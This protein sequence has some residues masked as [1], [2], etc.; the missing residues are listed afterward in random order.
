VLTATLRSGHATL[1]EFSSRQHIFNWTRSEQLPS[2]PGLLE[3]MGCR[4]AAYL[5]VMV[6]KIEVKQYLLNIWH[7]SP[8]ND[9]AVYEGVGILE[10]AHGQM[11]TL[12]QL[13]WQY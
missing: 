5:S 10:H 12:E 2:Q 6:Y 8:H 13:F 9:N 1:Y 7:G 3:D 11:L 4:L